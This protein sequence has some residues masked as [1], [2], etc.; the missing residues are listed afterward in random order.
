MPFRIENA[1]V[2][3]DQDELDKACFV[4]FS[5]HN[6]GRR[7]AINC[8]AQIYAVYCNSGIYDNYQGFPLRWANRPINLDYAKAERLNIGLDETEFVDLVFT[9]EVDNDIHFQKGHNVKIGF[10]EILKPEQY[11]VEI[12]FSGDNFK[13]SRL[14]FKISKVNNND[15]NGIIVNMINN[16]I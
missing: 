7:P 10:I 6:R 1:N 16:K 12:I 4:R 14:K 13:S 3:N 9:T 11:T 2:P 15:P 8:R 5:V